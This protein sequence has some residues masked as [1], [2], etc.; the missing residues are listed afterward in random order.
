M[1]VHSKPPGIW[2]V[3]AE[4]KFLDSNPGG[5]LSSNPQLPLQEP[6]MPS[7]GDHKAL[8]GGTL[9]AVGEEV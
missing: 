4:F 1:A 3:V 2:S 9:G 7:H 6:K 5:L 8:N